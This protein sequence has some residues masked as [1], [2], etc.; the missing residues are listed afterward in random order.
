M[1]DDG[2][3]L[4]VRPGQMAGYQN[5]PTRKVQGQRVENPEHDS[6]YLRFEQ[7][8]Q[9]LHSAVDAVHKVRSE[10]DESKRAVV[11]TINYLASAIQL[12]TLIREQVLK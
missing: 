11:Q 12:A 9:N 8:R 1:S 3:P 10:A 5:P 6:L 4:T 7:L 2:D